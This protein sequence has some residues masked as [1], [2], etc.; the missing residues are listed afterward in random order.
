ML[1]TQV[2][3]NIK[4][5]TFACVLSEKKKTQQ[6]PQLLDYFMDSE[7]VRYTNKKSG[8]RRTLGTTMV[9]EH[10][11]MDS[12]NSRGFHKKTEYFAKVATMRSAI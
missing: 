11:W 1:P 10:R 6:I 3:H 5:H 12:V 8:K 2:Y 9:Q 7:A 4:R